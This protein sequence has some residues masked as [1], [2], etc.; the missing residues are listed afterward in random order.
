[1]TTGKLQI[2]EPIPFAVS[3][4][5]GADSG[6]QNLIS[7][8]PKEIYQASGAGARTLL[9]DFGAAVTLDSL[10]LG[11]VNADAGASLRVNRYTGPGAT[12]PSSVVSPTA[13][14]AADAVANRAV[15]LVQFD[16]TAS[17]YWG[18]TIS[19]NTAALQIGALLAGLAFEAEWDREWGSGRQ[20][21]DLGKSQQLPGG[22]FGIQKGA[23]KSAYSW[24][25]GELTDEEL[26]RLWGIV[27]R[28]GNTDPVVVAERAGVAVGANESLHYGLLQR[29]DKFDRREPRATRWALEIEDWV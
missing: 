22:G 2:I 15:S 8:D 3:S 9:M 11:Y 20:P 13:I 18:V 25:F 19:G 21:I 17:R 29:L 14:R 6:V 26:E 16:P 27:Y 28:V 4:T 23:R 5:T 24:T 7:V 12:G 1:M 10:F